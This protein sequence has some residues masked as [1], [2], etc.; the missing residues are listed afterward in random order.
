METVP[1]AAVAGQVL[2][3]AQHG[4]GRHLPAGPDGGDDGQVGRP[5]VA[6]RDGDHPVPG[7]TAREGDPARAGRMDGLAGPGEQIDP[8][9]AGPP[10][11]GGRAETAE[12]RGDGAQRPLPRAG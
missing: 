11:N 2:E 5:Q 9:M 12:H 6:V 8:A 10:G 4:P 3:D 7:D 1:E